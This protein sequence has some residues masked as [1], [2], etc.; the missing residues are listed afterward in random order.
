M[1][2]SQTNIKHKD[3][4]LWNVYT[5]NKYPEYNRSMANYNNF[6]A[7]VALTAKTEQTVLSD[8]A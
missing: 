4:E 1:E 6:T 5:M 2:L 3:D 7:F 8:A